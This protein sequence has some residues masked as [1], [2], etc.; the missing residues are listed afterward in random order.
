MIT[1]INDF[2]INFIFKIGK[3]FL[4]NL[5]CKILERVIK[6]IYY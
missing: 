2:E 6:T 1:I 3:T 5:N 4:N